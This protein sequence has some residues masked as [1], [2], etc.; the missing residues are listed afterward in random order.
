MSITPYQVNLRRIVI[1]C[2]LGIILLFIFLGWFFG[3]EIKPKEKV[4]REDAET[5]TKYVDCGDHDEVR[6][7]DGTVFYAGNQ[8]TEYQNGEICC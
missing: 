6:F 8:S 4:I 2:W 3:R 1:G 7:K 5:G